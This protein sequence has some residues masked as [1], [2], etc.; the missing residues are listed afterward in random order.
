M[1]VDQHP[2]Q[3]ADALANRTRLLEIAREAF[4]ADPATSLNSIA[5]M[6]RVGAGTLYRHFPNREALLIAVYRNEIDELVALAPALL[7][8]HAPL[9]AFRQWCDRFA[10]FGDLKHGV[11]D[12]LSAAL[13]DQQAHY[14]YGALLG[15]ARDL[16]QA[17]AGAGALSTDVRPEDVLA[18]LS[19][20][21]RIA[22]T[23]D[24]KAQRRRLI[25]L[26]VAG[27]AASVCD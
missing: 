19:T 12:T 8:D 14:M 13:G 17:G 11:A 10:A 27:L 25:A 18:L 3:R 20:L 16:L 21:L 4:A 22:P 6:A 7:Q 5:K 2:G 24:G 1:A 9:T 15:A 26:I 23:P